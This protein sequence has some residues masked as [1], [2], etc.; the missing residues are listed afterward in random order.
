MCA[1]S[2]PTLNQYG[3]SA[4]KSHLIFFFVTFQ[5]FF[6]FP[7]SLSFSLSPL[8]LVLCTMTLY[9]ALHTCQLLLTLGID[10]E[11]TIYSKISKKNSSPYGSIE[12]IHLPNRITIAIH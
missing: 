6:S 3:S 5:N 11:S 10:T 9:N 2:T 1:K 4:P 7:L 12:R 8:T